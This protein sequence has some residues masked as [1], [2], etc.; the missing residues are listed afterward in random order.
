MTRRQ[1]ASLNVVLAFLVP[2]VL[3]FIFAALLAL[4]GR[5]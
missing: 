2:V 5:H 1:K 4:Y 3:V